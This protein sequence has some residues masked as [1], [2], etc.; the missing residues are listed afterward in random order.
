MSANYAGT[1]DVGEV[2]ACWQGGSPDASLAADGLPHRKCCDDCAFRDHSQRSHILQACAERGAAFY[3]VHQDA[4]GYRT[5]MGEPEPT[6]TLRVCA[7]FA[8][9]DAARRAKVSA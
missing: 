6:D 3:C 5:L 4:D 2:P 7:G 8:A 9:F 1:P